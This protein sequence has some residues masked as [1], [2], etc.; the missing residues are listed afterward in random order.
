MYVVE[1]CVSSGS[2]VVE[3]FDRVRITNPMRAGTAEA[4]PVN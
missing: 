4:T 3:E 1:W 2:Y